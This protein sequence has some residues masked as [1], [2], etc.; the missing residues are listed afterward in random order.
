M[1]LN[2]LLNMGQQIQ[3]INTDYQLT[4]LVD[5]FETVNREHRHMCKYYLESNQVYNRH[6]YDMTVTLQELQELLYDD[7]DDYEIDLVPII[8]LYNSYHASSNKYFLDYG[9]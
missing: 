4:V 9:M 7:L 8:Y 3:K 5:W 6:F 1:L 2:G